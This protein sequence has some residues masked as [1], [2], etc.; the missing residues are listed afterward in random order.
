MSKSV[1]K[2]E[3]GRITKRKSRDRRLSK[4]Y[5][6]SHTRETGGT[7]NS[8]YIEVQ[9]DDHRTLTNPE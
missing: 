4:N 6:P 8:D 3:Q 5:R 9:M 1:I 2:N 7:L